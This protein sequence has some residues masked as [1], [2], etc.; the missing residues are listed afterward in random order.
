MGGYVGIFK[1]DGKPVIQM[2]DEEQDALNWA[3]E[4]AEK[5]QQQVNIYRLHSEVE[6]VHTVNVREV[7]W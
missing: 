1:R 5:M 7:T 6:P 3:T 2:F 4:R